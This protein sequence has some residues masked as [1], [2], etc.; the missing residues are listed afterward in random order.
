MNGAYLGIDT[1]NY[2]T[3]AALYD[4]ESGSVIS[5]KKL[6]PVAQSQCG[7]RQSDAVF[8]HVKQLPDIIAQL[9][10]ETDLPIRAVCASCAP[11]PV[12]GSYMPA[13]LVGMCVG[14]SVSSLLNVPY[15]M[16]SHQEGHI[17][18]ALYSAQ[19]LSLRAQ[20]FYAFH[21]SGGTTECLSVTPHETGFCVEKIAGTLDLNA[22]Q[23]VDR[24]GVMLEMGFP[25]GME[26]DR[27]A[28][29]YEGKL[30]SIRV[31]M[32]GADCHFSGAQNQC[33]Q[34]FKAGHPKEMVARYA[35][36]YIEKAID[37]MTAEVLKQH[38]DR[39]IVYAGGV[40]SNTIIR[41]ALTKKYGGYFAEPAFSSDNAA[42]V[43]LIG[44]L[45]DS[46]HE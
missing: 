39:P 24:V 42:G 6:L 2:T 5:K 35:I 7:L 10:A 20:P 33:E 43:A 45:K 12:E 18:A 17:M 41:A 23:L 15:Y 27:L 21:V 32:K 14:E 4:P 44:A 8:L 28:Q 29:S 3:S 9:R 38:G 16:C 37:S 1:S 22:G 25:C 31:P 46:I 40:M 34:L 19:A 13:F 36:S 26:L 11:R 30:P